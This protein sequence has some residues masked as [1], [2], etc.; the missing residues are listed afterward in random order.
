MTLQINRQ[1]TLVIG[2]KVMAKGI[3]WNI[4]PFSLA[5]ITCAILNASRPVINHFETKLT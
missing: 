5:L 3:K 2:T 1:H 4:R